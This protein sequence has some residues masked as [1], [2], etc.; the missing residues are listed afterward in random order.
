M[1]Y[2]MKNYIRHF[3]FTWVFCELTN[4]RK[5][6]LEGSHAFENGLSV[7]FIS[8]SFIFIRYCYSIS[9]KLLL[10]SSL[11]NLIVLYAINIWEK[12]FDI[13]ILI[14]FKIVSKSTCY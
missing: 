3:S 10:I 4:Y 1:A 14:I 6:I 7:K 9:M 8:R 11:K 2:K 13:V 12:L 5:S